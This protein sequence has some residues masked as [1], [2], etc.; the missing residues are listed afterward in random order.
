VLNPD[1]IDLIERF[2]EATKLL[3]TTRVAQLSRI[4]EPTVRRL[5]EGMPARLTTDVRLA[6]I[7]YLKLSGSVGI[8]RETTEDKPRR[9]A[10]R[11][12]QL[13]EMLSQKNALRRMAQTI[14]DK[15]LVK[16]AY[17]IAIDDGWSE[18]EMKQLDV[19]R[20]EILGDEADSG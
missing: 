12:D 14:S 5:R 18:E 9:G 3:S 4:S 17:A 1:D 10:G 11:S 20:R 16:V 8:S 19:W 2:N 7:S 15:D 13:I 6:M